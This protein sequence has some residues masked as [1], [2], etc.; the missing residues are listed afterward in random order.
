MSTRSHATWLLLNMGLVVAVLSSA[1]AVV[2]TSHHCRSLYA[3]LQRMQSDQW[4]MQEHWGR[5]LLEQSTWAAH[6]RVESL[7]RRQLDMHLPAAAE[8]QVVTP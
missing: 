5:L 3:E 1:V 4:A 6:D 7:A 2:E 8:L